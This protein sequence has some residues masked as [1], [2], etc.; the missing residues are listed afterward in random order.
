M[1][2]NFKKN[3]NRS[4]RLNLTNLIIKSSF[5][6]FPYNYENDFVQVNYYLYGK[7]YRFNSDKNSTGHQKEIK[8]VYD[9]GTSKGLELIAHIGIPELSYPS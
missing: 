6:Y 8:K 1:V 9:I 5:N 4:F 7:C 2:Y 3:T